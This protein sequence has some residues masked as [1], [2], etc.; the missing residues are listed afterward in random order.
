MA[1]NVVVGIGG[2]AT[3]ADR[4]LEKVKSKLESVNKKMA[5]MEAT[6]K[7][8]SNS[9]IQDYG[10]VANSMTAVELNLAKL[11]L[12]HARLKNGTAEYHQAIEKTSNVIPKLGTGIS[13][14]TDKTSILL[15]KTLGLTS[16][17]AVALKTVSAISDGYR[18]TI[19]LRDASQVTLGSA[20]TNAAIAG[21]LGKDQIGKVSGLIGSL[22]ERSGISVES[23]GVATEK[24][25]G[26]GVKLNELNKFKSIYSLSAVTGKESGGLVEAV[27]SGLRREGISPDKASEA[28]VKRISGMI[29]GTFGREADQATNVFKSM[30]NKMSNVDAMALTEI[31]KRKNAGD[32]RASTGDVSEAT[33]KGINAQTFKMLGTTREEFEAVKSG[34][35][36][37]GVSSFDRAVSL[38]DTSTQAR[39]NRLKT[40]DIIE[41]NAGGS[42]EEERAKLNRNFY[43]NKG[44][45]SETVYRATKSLPFMNEDAVAFVTD[46]I[47]EQW[48][49]SKNG[50]RYKER[51]QY[52]NR[53][54]E[55]A[56]RD[57]DN[58][59]FD[60]AIQ[61][62]DNKN[63]RP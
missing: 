53:Y 1:D 29:F 11:H 14:V 6:S 2:D 5:Q 49:E 7:G 31:A 18:E 55:S 20:A 48:D 63:V 28:D 44:A 50:G 46:M 12:G 38:Y 45:G 26:S 25:L 30:S 32:I 9:I 35:L 62:N 10:R 61:K 39:Q 22:A 33:K 42:T 59:S 4:E 24:L 52:Q 51:I 57:I 60:K 17:L 15:A 3:Q 36:S 8:V 37:N 13:N 58:R 47:T 34:I 27:L 56:T 40:R 16:A 21:G 54:F 41:N 23:S 43:K 19:A